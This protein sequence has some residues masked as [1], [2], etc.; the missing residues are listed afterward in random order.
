LNRSVWIVLALLTLLIFGSW[1]ILEGKKNLDEY[2]SGFKPIFPDG[3]QI[4][5]DPSIENLT[6]E[7]EFTPR[8]G[9]PEKPKSSVWVTLKFWTTEQKE[10][11]FYVTMPYHIDWTPLQKPHNTEGT[12]EWG[13]EDRSGGT[14]INATFLP[15]KARS[16]A[17]ISNWFTFNESISVQDR[18]KY[19]TIIPIHVT[20]NIIPPLGGI[21]RFDRINT[22]VDVFIP[23]LSVPAGDS[24][25]PPD[26]IILTEEEDGSRSKHLIWHLSPSEFL[27]PGQ[28]ILASYTLSDAK[29]AF[30]LKLSFAVLWLAVGIST[31]VT[32]SVEIVREIASRRQSRKDNLESKAHQ[33]DMQEVSMD[34]ETRKH[35]LEEYRILNSTI[36]SR[37]NYSNIHSVKNTITHKY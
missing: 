12:E 11:V 10:H 31:V 25:P 23:E 9:T 8:E 5:G 32:G 15:S 13:F 27:D 4:Y 22:T 16:S 26:Q 18:G 20:S 29:L 21:Q 17:R 24:Y 35:I 34:E 14:L 28:T 3:I 36:E 7:L 6:A 1:A 33:A 19:T 37:T 2:A 30:D